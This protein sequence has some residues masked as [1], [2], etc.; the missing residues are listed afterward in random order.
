MA[1]GSEV[2]SEQG[3]VGVVGS[4]VEVKPTCR[5]THGIRFIFQFARETKTAAR[6]VSLLGFPA[7]DSLWTFKATSPL[8]AGPLSRLT[9]SFR[10]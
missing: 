8:A 3:G 7:T 4:C 2:R 5:G 9:A 1:E 6:M 10:T